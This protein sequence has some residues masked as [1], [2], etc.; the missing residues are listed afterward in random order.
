[1][2][3][4]LLIVLFFVTGC[5]TDKVID[6]SLSSVVKPTREQLLKKTRDD[7]LGP[8]RALQSVEKKSA[9]KNK[10]F[11]YRNV[12]TAFPDNGKNQ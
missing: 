12:A 8:N 7:I 6:G 4:R 3:V 9:A 1:M 2:D 11:I 5:A 10:K